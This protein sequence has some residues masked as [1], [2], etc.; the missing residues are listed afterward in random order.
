MIADGGR[1]NVVKWWAIAPSFTLLPHIT[2]LSCEKAVI[3][4]LY[5]CKTHT[6]HGA[7]V[8][9]FCTDTLDIRW[10]YTT[11]RCE[12]GNVGGYPSNLH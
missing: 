4:P 10:K 5:T 11:L 8:E 12:W 6:Y 7:I 3:H 1:N 9:Y 2:A